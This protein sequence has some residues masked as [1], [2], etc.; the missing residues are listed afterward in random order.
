MRPIVLGLTAVV[1]SSRAAGAI[2][3]GAD[4][5]E[6]HSSRFDLFVVLLI[7]F[8]IGEV[9]ALLAAAV[10]FSVCLCCC[11]PQ[12]LDLPLFF[13]ILLSWSLLSLFSV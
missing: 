10:V 9:F 7:L 4:G 6:F 1:L 8:H 12:R 3:F 2:A 11:V 5:G 13:A